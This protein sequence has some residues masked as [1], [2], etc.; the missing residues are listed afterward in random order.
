MSI[1]ELLHALRE[2][3]IAVTV[4]ASELTAG[5]ATGLLACRAGLASALPLWPWLVNVFALNMKRA[6]RS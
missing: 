6:S 3:M 4:S 1:A 2:V 5:G